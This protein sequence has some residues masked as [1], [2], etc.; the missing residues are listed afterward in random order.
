MTRIF[1]T[2]FLSIS[3]FNIDYFIFFINL[4]IC[5]CFLPLVLLIPLK[6][7]KIQNYRITQ[8]RRKNCRYHDFI[9]IYI[10]IYIVKSRANVC[11]CVLNSKNIN[12]FLFFS[13]I[14]TQTSQLEREGTKQ[15]NIHRLSVFFC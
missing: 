3:L 15:N 9:Y 4:K 8:K 1:F 6:F 10:F 2:L 14:K 12:Y 7:F 5:S 11:V 13:K